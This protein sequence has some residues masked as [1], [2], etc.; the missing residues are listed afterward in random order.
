VAA[1]KSG[2]AGKIVAKP[3]AK[4]PAKPAPAKAK[5]AKPTGKPQKKKR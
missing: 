2:K 4:K 1:R 5:S 3:A